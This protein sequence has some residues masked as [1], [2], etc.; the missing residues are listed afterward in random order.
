MPAKKPLSLIERHFTKEERES[1]LLRE[2][3]LE[4]ITQLSA[5]IPESLQGKEYKHAAQVWKKSIDLYS[6]LQSKVATSLDQNL[7]IKY[8]K[9]DQQFIE[10]ENLRSEKISQ[11]ESC[12]EKAKRIKMTSDEKQLKTWSNMWHIVNDMEKIIIVLD[13]RLDGKGKYLHSLEQSLYLTPRSR[14]GVAPTE[15][16]KEKEDILKRFD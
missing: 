9:A 3:A 4:P 6:E 10:L 16:A 12:K 1:R 8:C 5:D 13:A 15:K 7:L 11:W 14:S 2:S